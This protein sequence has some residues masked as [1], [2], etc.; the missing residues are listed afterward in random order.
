MRRQINLVII[1][2]GMDVDAAG[3]PS[4]LRGDVFYREPDARAEEQAGTY[5]E[6]VQSILAPDLRG[7][8]GR[9]WYKL[10]EGLLE[11]EYF[12]VIVGS[13]DGA[14]LIRSTGRVLGGNGE[15]RGARG[16]LTSRSEFSLNPFKLRVEFTLV[17]GGRSAAGSRSRR[18]SRARSSR[19]W[20]RGSHPQASW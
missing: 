15:F 5:W 18:L 6:E 13:S 10:N 8:R 20:R 19:L 17:L 2:T 1:G 7:A 16:S 4:R 12:S 11:T 3:L 14:L 9:Q